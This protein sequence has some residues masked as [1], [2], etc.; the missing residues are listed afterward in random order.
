M[1]IVL[2]G[3]IGLLTAARRSFLGER[4][5]R[6]AHDGLADRP[7]FMRRLRRRG[8]LIIWHA[9]MPDRMAAI[10]VTAAQEAGDIV[11]I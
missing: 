6:I 2:D 11:A 1:R 7:H 9:I 3:K 10:I 4:A 5:W 8:T